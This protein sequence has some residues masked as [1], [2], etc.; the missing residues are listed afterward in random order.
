LKLKGYSPYRVR[1]AAAGTGGKLVLIWAAFGP[2]NA[3]LPWRSITS[4]PTARQP[5]LWV[6]ERNT[7]IVLQFETNAAHAGNGIA[8]IEL[9]LTGTAA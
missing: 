3:V 7:E 9:K 2:A 6:G 1:S 5:P 8:E 4:E